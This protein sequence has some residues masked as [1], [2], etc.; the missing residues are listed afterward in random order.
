MSKAAAKAKDEGS[1]PN[2]DELV[3]DALMRAFA[4]V[5]P[6]K[7]EELGIFLDIALTNLDEFRECTGSN[8]VRMFRVLESWKKASKSPTVR[9][10]LSKFELIGVCREAIRRKFEEMSKN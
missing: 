5:S 6:S 7:W 2:D 10:L 8:F 9:Q 1:F 3:P 4:A